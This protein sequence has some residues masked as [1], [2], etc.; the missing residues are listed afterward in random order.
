MKKHVIFSIFSVICLGLVGCQKAKDK[1]QV[2]HWERYHE[3]YVYDDPIYESID[4]TVDDAYPNTITIFGI[5]FSGIKQASWDEYNI[6][7]RCS[8]TNGKMLDY[9]L[10]E[11]NIPIEHRHFF[12]EVGTHKLELQYGLTTLSFEFKVINNENFKG[13]N[14]YFFDS[15]DK[16]LHTQNVGYYETVRYN[17]P[18][19]T[20]EKDSDDFSYRFA[21]WNRNT[22]FIH[23]DMQFKALV[24]KVEKRS[25]ALKPYQNDYYSI[26]G[27]VDKES[28]TGSALFYLGRIHR[29]AT[30]YG[31]SV[32][33]DNQDV[34]LSFND[35]DFGS[36]WNKLNREMISKIKYVNDP[37]F[38]SSIYGSISSLI[39]YPNFA[40]QIPVKY[41]YRGGN[42]VYLEN[43][44]EILL[45]ATSPYKHLSNAILEYANTSEI[46][47]IAGNFQG[48][49][50]LAVVFDFD[51]YCSISIKR[52]GNKLYELG[53]EN[54]FICCPDLLSKKCVVQFSKNGEFKDEFN[55][56]LSLSS[57]TI[58][59]NAN[60]L[61]W[62]E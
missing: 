53:S 16:L 62:E 55:T 12:G 42:K 36:N 11:K 34:S 25:Y 30:M 19:V 47:K 7:I 52:I 51:I 8:Y 14:C 59:N 1:E 3:E 31:D 49:Y 20:V 13:Y 32:E 57:R 61:N 58:C 60:M 35:F 28:Q 24:E 46:V 2:E 15:K 40:T 18:D 5:P 38:D 6:K 44:D 26:G 29:V 22:K 39:S 27:L 45:S 9:P 4:V 41:N 43:K 21:G 56:S 10:Y 23:Q 37:D 33:L 17:G 48:F 54:T 50:R